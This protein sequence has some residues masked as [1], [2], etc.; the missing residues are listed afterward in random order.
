MERSYCKR[1]WV[2][3][4]ILSTFA[5]M[6]GF[7]L[8]N[9]IIPGVSVGGIKLGI[10]TKQL[11]KLMGKPDKIHPASDSQKKFWEYSKPTLLFT[12]KND[13]VISIYVYRDNF[14]TPSGIKVG[15]SD[16]KIWD[17]YLQDFQTKRYIMEE[18]TLGGLSVI[19]PDRGIGFMV[20]QDI[21]TC[22]MILFPNKQE[23]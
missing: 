13:K 2:L 17:V 6:Y 20:K 15:V 10:T 14:Q 21:V 4:I 23:K 11:Q 12:I 7:K 18:N 3:L 22:I 19:L 9:E 5:F 8:N 1:Y 16:K